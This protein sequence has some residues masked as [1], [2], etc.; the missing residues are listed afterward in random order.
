MA[1]YLELF[2]IV[3]SP[4]IVDLRKRLRVSIIIKANAIAKASSPS[5]AAKAFAR[6]ALADPQSYEDMVLRYVV[7][8]NSAATTA[9]IAAATDAQVQTAVNAAI[10]T[11][12]GA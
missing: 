10:D 1:T 3:S 6:A 7:A 2:D 5:D 12:L 9:Q 11:L 8:D 4:T